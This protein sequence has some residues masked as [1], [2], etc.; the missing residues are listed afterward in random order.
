MAIF[1]VN[2]KV[3]DF[4]AWKKVYDNHGSIRDKYKVTGKFVLK[5][6]DDP[7]NVTVIGEGE[8]GDIQNF[9]NSDDLKNAMQGAGVVSTPVIF[10]G[11]N[12]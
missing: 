10:V 4:G 5:S 11:A 6:I 8:P 7:N 9:L 3:N 1:V 2:H 12:S